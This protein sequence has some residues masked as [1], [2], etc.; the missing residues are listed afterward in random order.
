[1]DV[2]PLAVKCADYSARA[3]LGNL[4]PD[5]IVSDHGILIMASSLKIGFEIPE[6]ERS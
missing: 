1:V 2:V 3:L 4:G 6:K 5:G